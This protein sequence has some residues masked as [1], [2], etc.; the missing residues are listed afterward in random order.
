MTKRIDETEPLPPC[1]KCGGISRRVYRYGIYSVVCDSCG[2]SSGG[3]FQLSQAEQYWRECCAPEPPVGT[4]AD[5]PMPPV[6]PYMGNEPTRAHSTDAGLDLV[7]DETV[8]IMPGELRVVP[9]GTRVAIPEGCAG[10]LMS[11]SGFSA[12]TC[13][14][15]VSG[16][17]LIDPGYIG[18]M[19]LPFVN[20]G[21]TAQEVRKGD[22]VAQLVV[23]P[24][25]TPIPLEVDSLA[26]SERGEGGFGSTGR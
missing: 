13:L 8:Y 16:N 9:T 10:F 4:A 5:A 19:S 26:G 24:V 2:Y 3:S 12:E 25:L 23:V 20:V 15:L 14:M 6:L 18:E 21:K 7:A 22:R 11:R 1:P 17:G